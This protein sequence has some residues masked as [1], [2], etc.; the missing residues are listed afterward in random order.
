MPAAPIG[1]V[2][3]TGSWSDTTWEAGT[4]ANAV[5]PPPSTSAGGY[6]YGYRNG[7]GV[8]ALVLGLTTFAFGDPANVTM[9]G[10]VQ[11]TDQEQQEGYFQLDRD[12]VIVVRPGSERQEQLKQ[13]VGQSV[14]VVIE[15][16]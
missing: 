13:M 2:W 5:I 9:R 10:T 4:W 14:I 1:S 16:R 7:L 6:H 8:L 3:A 11:A 15:A 12:T